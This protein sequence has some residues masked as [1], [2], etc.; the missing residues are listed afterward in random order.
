MGCNIIVDANPHQTRVAVVED[1]ALSEIYFERKGSERIV[2]NIYKGVV[3][4]VLPGMQAAFVNIGYDKNAFLYAGDIAVDNTEFEFEGSKTLEPASISDIV[5]QGEEIVVQVLKEPGDTKGARITTN[6][7]L[8]GRLSVIMPTVDYVGVSRRICDE[9][10][11]VRLKEIAERVKPEGVGVIVRTA[12]IGKNSAELEDEICFLARLWGRVKQRAELV[13]APRMIHSE[14]SLIFRTVRDMLNE[15]IDAM[16]INDIDMFERV[17]VVSD[18]IAPKLSDK[19]KLFTEHYDIFDYFAIEE[20]VDRTMQRRVWLKSGGY[21]I[22][23]QTEALT[24][25]DINTGKYVGTVNFDKTALQTNLEAATEIARQLR[26]R[27]ISGIIVIDFIDMKLDENRESVME[28]LRTALKKDRTKS[29][30]IGMTGLGLVEMTRKKV[31]QPV[32]SALTKQCTYCHGDGRIEN[33]D[34]VAMK[35]RKQL[36]RE[37]NETDFPVFVIEVHTSVAQHITKSCEDAFKNMPGGEGRKVFLKPIS[38]THM[39]GVK[40]YGVKNTFV[41]DMN[42]IIRLA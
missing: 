25:I 24:V 30:V 7:T 5:K 3:A 1:N 17:K 26:L 8:P 11:R 35:A 31:R 42:G 14:D 12:A 29:N 6:V 16:Y 23:D 21:L 22:I 10:E 28:R 19:I 37:I 33:E 15:N 40:V 4:N 20:A 32:R 41:I 39:C 34:T 18:M 2:G 38:G 36:L 27:D 9:D 13:N